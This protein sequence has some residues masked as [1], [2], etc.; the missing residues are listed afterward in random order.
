M[1]SDWRDVIDSLLF[2]PPADH[3]QLSRLV[4]DPVVDGRGSGV[5]PG[6]PKGAAVRHSTPARRV[7]VNLKRSIEPSTNS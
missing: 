7:V 3:L 6:A 2:Q 1:S 4:P 5:G